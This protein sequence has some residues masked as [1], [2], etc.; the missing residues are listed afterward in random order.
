MIFDGEFGLK[1]E[2]GEGDLINPR[3][4]ARGNS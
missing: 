2:K 4:K 1:P 3:A